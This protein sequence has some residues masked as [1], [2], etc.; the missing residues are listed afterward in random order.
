MRVSF[1]WLNEYV[2]ISDLSAEKVADTLTDI[3]HE[4]EGMEKQSTLPDQLIVGEILTAVPHP[5]ADSLQ[6]CTVN[7]GEAEPLQIVC[8]APNARPGIKVAVA[9]IGTVLPGDFKIKKGKIRGEV[10]N[11]MLCSETE[12]GIGEGSDGI[13]ELKQ[14]VLP[15][16]TVARVLGLD[17]TVFEVNVTPNR[18]DC[19]GVIGLARDLAARLKKPLRKIEFLAVPDQLLKTKDNIQ[20][21]IQDPDS[22]GRFAALYISDVKTMPSPAWMQQRLNAAGMRP[23]NLIVDATNYAMLEYSQPVH[24]YDERF[25][26]G[27]KIVV[28][29]AKGGEKLVTLDGIERQLLA[30]D[31]MICDGERTI[32]LA[33]VMGGQ[34]SE[35]SDETNALVIEVAH[36]SPIQIRKTARRLGMHTEASHRFERG[37]DI[38]NLVTVAHR[39]A[40]LIVRGAHEA[41]AAGKDVPI[42]KVASSHV[43]T[44][45]ADVSKRVVAMRLSSVKQLLALPS[46]TKDGVIATLEALEFVLLDTTD[47]RMV[48]EVPFFRNDIEREMDLVEEIG[49]MV[50]YDRVP[51]QLPQMNIQ[52]NPEDAF[53]D[54]QEMVRENISGDG[55]RETITFPFVSGQEVAGLGLQEDHPLHPSLSLANPLNDQYASMQTTLLP[56]LIRAI[57]A[58]R[59]RGEAGARLFECGRGYFDFSRRAIDAQKYPAFRLWSRPARHITGKAK[60]D[61]GRPVERHLAAGIIDHPFSGKSWNLPPTPASFFHGKAS[62]LTLFRSFA[63]AEP[64]FERPAANEVPF[65]NPNASAL[66][67]IGNRC[68]GYVGEIHPRTA[69]KFD[70]SADEAPVVFEVDLETLFESKGRGQKA[71]FNPSKFPQTSRDLALLVNKTTSHRDFS[72]AVAKFK[73]KK[74]LTGFKLF[75]LYEGDKLPAGKKSMAYTF[76]FQSDERTLTDQEVEQE[77]GG[78]LTLFTESLGASQ[79]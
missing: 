40:D 3:G 72:D 32:G 69:A 43:D 41:R 66:V 42:P 5:N 47:D 55:Y 22:C 27:K 67:K 6:L 36:F 13:I 23:I 57:A 33:G 14:H 2:D 25:I 75:D 11:G 31:I 71:G 39:V 60:T 74:H 62:I 35:V 16:Q 73:G 7:I 49:R 45:P 61:A 38:D 17:D 56:G 9:T 77:V 34:N 65:L 30:G 50:G 76:Y 54:F 44:Y 26:H 12:L 53:I 46:L 63:I 8:G 4:I 19:L 51:F 10:S 64:V 59:K 29:P 68:V 24:A 37:I 70:L 18:G 52:P 21:D 48:F 78:L 28:R 58:N 79:R 20:V 1:S 15:G